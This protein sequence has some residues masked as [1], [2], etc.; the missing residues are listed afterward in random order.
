MLATTNAECVTFP[1]LF[2]Q[3]G[4]AAQSVD[5]RPDLPASPEQTYDGV[6]LALRVTRKV[7][8]TDH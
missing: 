1:Q 8:R 4:S 7:T 3:I 2:P 6:S 5:P